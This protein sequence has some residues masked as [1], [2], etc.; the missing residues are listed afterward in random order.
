MITTQFEN[1]QTQTDM[2]LEEEKDTSFRDDELE[3]LVEAGR[4][5][6]DRI[7]KNELY[8][9]AKYDEIKRQKLDLLV[10][11]S[12]MYQELKDSQDETE[13]LKNERKRLIFQLQKFDDQLGHD[14]DLNDR[15]KASVFS[16]VT[17]RQNLLND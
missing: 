12:E 16:E 17:P 2:V 1:I 9:K 14:D 15:I 6:I 5:Q 7:H 11:K 4:Q 10:T 13:D 8:W 3:N